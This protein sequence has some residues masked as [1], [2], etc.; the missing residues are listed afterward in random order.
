ML[1]SNALVL[2]AFRFGRADPATIYTH[3]IRRVE[4]ISGHPVGIV[5][6]WNRMRCAIQLGIRQD[7]V[8]A[9]NVSCQS[10]QIG[11]TVTVQRLPR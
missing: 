6:I 9:V 4:R 11:E 10:G 1:K 5:C 2:T 7:A 8:M 3:G